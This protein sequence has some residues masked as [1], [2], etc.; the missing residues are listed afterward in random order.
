MEIIKLTNSEWIE[1]VD[2]Y[3]RCGTHCIAYGIQDSPVV[4]THRKT[5]V[6][7][8]ICKELGYTVY[9]AF[10]NGGTILTEAGDVELGH[11]YAPQNG[12]RDRFVTFFVKW[13]KAKGLNAVYED[14]DVLVDGYK[15]CGT[16][17][18]RYGRIDYTGIHIGINTNL[19]HIIAICRKPMNKVPKGL[20]DYGIT[21][22]EVEQMFLDFCESDETNYNKGGRKLT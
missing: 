14:N 1:T 2:R 9:E 13:L 6:D 10:N 22:E 5:Q 20:S 11:W 4:L 21:S 15:V 7:E 18:T 8:R 17:I 16:C 3:I 19:D 12:W